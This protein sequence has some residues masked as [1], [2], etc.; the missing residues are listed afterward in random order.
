MDKLQALEERLAHQQ[1][2]LDELS[3]VIARQDT[4]IRRLTRRVGLLVEA[5]A[6]RA[7]DA[8]SIPLSD[9]RPPH[10]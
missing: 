2:M 10:W 9:Q 8:G 7:A 3:D 6:D 4:E 1:R 5:E